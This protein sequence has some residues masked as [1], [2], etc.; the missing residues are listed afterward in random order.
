MFLGGEPSPAAEVP[1]EHDGPVSDETVAPGED[2][3]L[4][5]IW[6]GA[7]DRDEL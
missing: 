3:A 6:P 1:T 7:A 4:D 2:D 5:T